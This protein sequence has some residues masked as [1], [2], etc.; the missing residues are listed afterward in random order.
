MHPSMEVGPEEVIPAFASPFIVVSG[1]VTTAVFVPVTVL[2][3]PFIS[4]FPPA[5]S[6][7]NDAA[8]LVISDFVEPFTVIFF[9]E[10]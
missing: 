4:A 8:P 10:I 6:V 5:A 1:A 2:V 3:V 7:V 9:P